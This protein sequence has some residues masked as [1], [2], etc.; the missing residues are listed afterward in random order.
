MQRGRVADPAG[1]SY[2]I[3]AARI[4]AA[5]I[6]VVTDADQDVIFVTEAFT[7]ITGYSL[8]E[9]H[10]RSC[11]LLQGPGTDRATTGDMRQ[12][13]RAGEVFEGEL[14]NYRKDGSAF[15]VTLKV[16]PM[17]LGP[18]HA[19][20][21]F[22][23][24]QRDISNRVA[25]VEQLR[26]QALRDHTTGLPNR[27]AAELAVEA[28]VRRTRKPGVTIVLGLI[29]L[30]DFRL[31]NNT[32]G[33]AAGDAVL[34]QWAD[35]MRAHLRE[36]DVLARMG[37]DEFLLILERTDWQDRSDVAGCLD[38][39]HRV[40]EEPFRA[41]GHEVVIGM[42][43]GLVP[44]QHDR[45]DHRYLLQLADE[46]LYRVKAQRAE[47]TNW[48]AVAETALHPPVVRGTSLPVGGSGDATTA[49]AGRRAGAEES[50]NALAAGSVEVQFQP[51]VDLRNGSLH[52]FE[53]LARLRMPDGRLAQPHEFL[54][55]LRPS[56]ERTL[57]RCVLGQ[58]L[59]ALTEWEGEGDRVGVSVNVA[60][61]VLQDPATPSIVWELLETR[62]IAPHR[63]SLEVLESQV[64]HLAVQ[65]AAIQKLVSLGVGLVMDDLSAGHSSL[66]RLASFPFEALK[67]DKGLFQGVS[68]KPLET[69][70]IMATLIQ[71][72]R[73]LNMG[74]VIEGLEDESLTEAAII[75]GAPLGQGYFL[76]RPLP[77]EACQDWLR[78]FELTLHQ[79]PIQTLLGAL[80]YHWQF[81]RLTAPHPLGLRHCPLTRFIEDL[82]P[83]AEVRAWHER[84]HAHQGVHPGSSRSLLAWLV[85]E[86]RSTHPSGDQ[87][88]AGV[89]R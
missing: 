74:V 58:A 70:S 31:V 62:A 71:M 72:G 57:F 82:S 76:A 80:A 78:S 79:T 37:G 15:W 48:W 87:A 21:H 9:M 75:L 32:Y 36:G 69:L 46:S 19:V 59:D 29:D 13:L 55:H 20:T 6:A 10:G 3:D 88:Q 50:R 22:V 30:D 53:A 64:I 26:V 7:A 4:A 49:V 51:V 2:V 67:L 45:A 60:P 44:V 83:P 52:L 34:Q 16:T 24:V 17:R 23:S 8:E 40:V 5:D 14:L 85:G 77:R 27:S 39:L 25:L 86:I 61:V 81:A 68:E 18:G 38:D 56:D 12:V 65:R 54:P 42:S 1:L 43:M 66:Q 35:R 63:L 47:R 84:Q 33:H 28:A 11:R 89:G 73:D 41:G